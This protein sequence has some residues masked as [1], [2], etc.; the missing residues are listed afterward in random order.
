MTATMLPRTTAEPT[1][2]SQ[3]LAQ[4]DADIATMDALLDG[5]GNPWQDK[6]IAE[7]DRAVAQRERLRLVATS[8]LAA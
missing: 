8:A 4:L 1:P 3:R 2:E 5:G 7:R 6:L